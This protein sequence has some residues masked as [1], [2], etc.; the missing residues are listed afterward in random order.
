MFD[1][2]ISIEKM[3]SIAEATRFDVDTKT[4]DTR[5][6]IIKIMRNVLHTP[7]LENLESIV[8]KK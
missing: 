7:L 8:A 1:D 6:Y 5:A 3:L 4:F 2:S